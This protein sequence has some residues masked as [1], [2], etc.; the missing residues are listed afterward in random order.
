MNR[1]QIRAIRSSFARDMNYSDSTWNYH[2]LKEPIM[3]KR[4]EDIRFVKCKN[5]VIYHQY[6]IEKSNNVFKMY[7]V[8]YNH[9]YQDVYVITLNDRIIYWTV[10][11][12]YAPASAAWHVLT[13]VY[14]GYNDHEGTWRWRSIEP[15][16]AI[17]EFLTR[18]YKKDT[19]W[20]HYSS[21]ERIESFNKHGKFIIDSKIISQDEASDLA[22]KEYY[23][24]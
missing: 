11:S 12:I 5:P 20:H 19:R 7:F 4:I 8:D 2:I 1:H 16:I 15:F 22:N 23:H 17:D 13:G 3:R 14:H 24:T 6:T 10:S 18:S 21:K 9:T